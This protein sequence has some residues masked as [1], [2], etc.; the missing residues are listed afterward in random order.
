M[1]PLPLQLARLLESYKSNV[2]NCVRA[3]DQIHHLGSI[4]CSAAEYV[5]LY[6]SVY[7]YPFYVDL[8]VNSDLGMCVCVFC[9]HFAH[10]SF[11]NVMQIE[12]FSAK[13]G[14]DYVF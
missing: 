12:M 1:D 6:L 11:W 5:W 10:K 8:N 9:A 7:I 13:Y 3:F 4:S 14:D 2:F